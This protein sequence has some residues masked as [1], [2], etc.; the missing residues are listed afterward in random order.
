MDIFCGV[1]AADGQGRFVLEL[2]LA[3]RLANLKLPV[4]FD[5]YA[6]MRPIP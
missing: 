1:F 6:R 5:A 3:R 2:E 4:V